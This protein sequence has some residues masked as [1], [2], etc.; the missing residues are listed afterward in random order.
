MEVSSDGDERKYQVLVNEEGQYSLWRDGKSIPNGWTAT[1]KYGAKEECI[2]YVD[3]VW[4]D[5]RPVSLRS[6]MR[7]AD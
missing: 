1:G 7:S 2:S 5:M 3:S 4:T 6:R